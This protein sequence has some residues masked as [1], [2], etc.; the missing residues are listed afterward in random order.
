MFLKAVSNS[1]NYN[2]KAI[3]IF[4]IIEMNSPNPLKTIMSQANTVTKLDLTSDPEV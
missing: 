4:C 2:T 3:M 1:F